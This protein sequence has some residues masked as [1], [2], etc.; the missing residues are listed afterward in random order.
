LEGMEAMGLRQCY[1][2]FLALLRHSDKHGGED[3]SRYYEYIENFSF[4]FSTIC[5][6]PTNTLER[7]YSKRAVALE[8]GLLEVKSPEKHRRYIVNELDGLLKE[9]KEIYKERSVS[10]LFGKSFERVKYSPRDFKS[11]ALIRYILSKF[12]RHYGTNETAINFGEVTVEHVLPQSP[13]K[14][15]LNKD[16]V[17]GYMHLLGNL[18]LLGKQ[19]NGDIG[20]ETLDI[21][22]PIYKSSEYYLTKRLIGILEALRAKYGK[23]DWKESDIIERQNALAA[24]A[25]EVWKI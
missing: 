21:K 15:G 3:L 5:Q 2:L 8:H 18:T 24:E 1:I 10:G 14:W 7:L 12:E 20:N 17:K 9:L 25:L 22:V 4:H 16:A 19:K 6:L 11:V 13:A 23:Y